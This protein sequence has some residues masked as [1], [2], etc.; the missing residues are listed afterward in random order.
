M[1]RQENWISLAMECGKHSEE[2]FIFLIHLQTYSVNQIFWPKTIYRQDR[3]VIGMML[4]NRL[5]VTL[6][7]DLLHD[8]RKGTEDASG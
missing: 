8:L 7:A 4:T 2:V 1:L 5:V 6:R 3:Y